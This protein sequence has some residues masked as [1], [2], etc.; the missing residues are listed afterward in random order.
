MVSI[1][2]NTVDYKEDAYDAADAAAEK[3]GKI[4]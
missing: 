4:N 2:G 1:R 3:S